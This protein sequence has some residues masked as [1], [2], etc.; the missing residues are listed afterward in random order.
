[1]GMGL[2]PDPGALYDPGG[3]R[4]VPGWDRDRICT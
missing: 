2:D 1:M 4:L 3:S